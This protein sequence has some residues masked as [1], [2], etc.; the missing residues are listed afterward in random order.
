VTP[1][2]LSNATLLNWLRNGQKDQPHKPLL[3]GSRHLKKTEGK[4]F[5]DE[6]QFNK[7]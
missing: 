6:L 3:I 4:N 2:G 5:M 7:A 1:K